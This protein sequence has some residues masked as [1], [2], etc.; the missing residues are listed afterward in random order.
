MEKFL[1]GNQ[2]DMD[3]PGE[4]TFIGVVGWGRTIKSQLI[5]KDKKVGNI[6]KYF[7]KFT[8]KGRS[9]SYSQREI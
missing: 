7:V 3:Q 2:G 6:D 1:F 9:R 5:F 8:V 4:N